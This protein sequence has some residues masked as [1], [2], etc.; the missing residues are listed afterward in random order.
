M[1][2]ISASPFV[3]HTGLDSMPE[4]DLLRRVEQFIFHEAECMDRCD[5]D[6]WIGLWDEDILYWA[7][8]NDEDMDP[9]RQISLIYD[10]REQL[11]QRIRRMKSHLA[12]A[13]NPKSRVMRVVSNIRIREVNAAD[14]LVSSSFVV[15]E[16]RLDLQTV[17]IGR[18]LHTLRPRADDFRI[19]QK[20][21]FLLNNASPLGNLQFL[22]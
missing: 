4:A 21:V 15:G 20:K 17:W 9:S 13:Q 16:L 22:I 11:E 19:K 6:N 10:R 1:D 12:H 2:R 18:S 5:Y 3:K 8:C 14:I 7:P